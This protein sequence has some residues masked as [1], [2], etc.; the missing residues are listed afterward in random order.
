[1]TEYI[2]HNELN[3]KDVNFK[4]GEYFPM[5]GVSFGGV[6]VPEGTVI[7]ANFKQSDKGV[8]AFKPEFILSEDRTSAIHS[9]KLLKLDFTAGRYFSDLTIIYPDGYEQ[10][11]A[12]FLITIENSTC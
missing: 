8:T 5:L 1:M 7:C 10:P 3:G 4:Q 2:L 6:V 12:R 9:G 11:L